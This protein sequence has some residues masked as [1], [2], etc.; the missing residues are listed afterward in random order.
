M[1][2]VDTANIEVKEMKALIV[3]RIKHTFLDKYIK[4]PV[5]DEDKLIILTGI[6]N[7]TSMSISKKK[8][9]II[10]TMLVQIALDTHELIPAS[11]DHSED[12]TA[13]TVKQLTVLAGDYFS[14]LYYLLLSEVEDFDMIRILASA[15]KEINEYKMKLYYKE[16]ESFDDFVGI[17]AKLESL[18]I[19]RVA[20]HVDSSIKHAI[21]GELIITS[22]LIKEKI[23]I[24]RK[25][26]SPI[27][28]NWLK[29]STT[30]S[31]SSVLN[32]VETIIEKNVIQI[33]SYLSE[34]P[35]HLPIFKTQVSYILN[36]LMYN[37]AAVAG[38]G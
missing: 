37:K 24:Q 3:D 15:I 14:G 20:E 9:Y 8:S 28:D 31:Y 5:I 30:S 17:V 22:K 36:E 27:V 6:I 18:L 26:P 16:V 1:I 33:E 12:E 23:N 13:Q 4:K 32:T 7:S 19:I 35:N 38:E 29:H 34:T 25:G 21:T 2:A 10:T 11:D